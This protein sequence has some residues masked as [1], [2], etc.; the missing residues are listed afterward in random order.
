MSSTPIAE[1]VRPYLNEVSWPEKKL[2]KGYKLEK[3]FDYTVLGE[4]LLVWVRGTVERIVKREGNQVKAEINWNNDDI[5]KGETA[6]TTDLLKKNQWII[7]KQKAGAWRQD[8]QHL[9]LKVD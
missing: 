2:K 1:A 3:L 5:G 6:T 9:E 4:R 7:A 8:L